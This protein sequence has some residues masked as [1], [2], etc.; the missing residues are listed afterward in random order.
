MKA[1]YGAIL[2]LASTVAA[3]GAPDPQ[4]LDRSCGKVLCT[5][6]VAVER[7]I[8]GI[9]TKAV[10]EFVSAPSQTLD[11]VLG[12]REGERHRFTAYCAHGTI[13]DEEDGSE[14]A[15][16]Q[17]RTPQGTPDPGAVPPEKAVLHTRLLKAA[18]D[19]ACAPGAERAEDVPYHGT[20]ASN[21]EQCSDP[22]SDA[23]TTIGDKW[24]LQ[25]ENRCEIRRTVQ[26]QSNRWWLVTDCEGEGEAHKATY[27]LTLLEKGKLLIEGGQGQ[28][29][30]R[31]EKMLCP[32]ETKA[33]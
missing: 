15:L 22:D 6:M 31:D 20:W 14:N 10:V 17:I 13:R 27:R 7:K 8:V 11:S 16:V 29:L 28:A 9:G 21:L 19:Y 12:V 18:M 4:V 2:L 32:A 3:S 23:K 25:W 30:G 5:A 24:L 26:S 33:Q 1:I